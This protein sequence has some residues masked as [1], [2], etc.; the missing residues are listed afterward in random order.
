MEGAPSAI[1]TDRRI[2]RANAA[3]ERQS[4][5]EA[6][7]ALREIL[8]G[9][10]SLACSPFLP[11]L[12]S[13]YVHGRIAEGNGFLRALAGRIP[14]PHEAALLSDVWSV[15]LHES[16]DPA[17]AAD[18]CRI[19]LEGAPRDPRLWT[20]LG[21]CLAAAGRSDEAI[22]AV[23]AALAR[24]PNHLRADYLKCRASTHETFDLHGQDPYVTRYARLFLEIVPPF[25][26]LSEILDV[27]LHEMPGDLWI[28]VSAREE[29]SAAPFPARPGL[30]V[31]AAT[32]NEQGFFLRSGVVNAVSPGL[33]RIEVRG[34][35]SEG[36]W[37]QRRSHIRIS[38]DDFVAEGLRV[39]MDAFGDIAVQDISG[40]GISFLSLEG[41][42][43]GTAMEI[44]LAFYGETLATAAVVRRCVPRGDRFLVGAEFLPDEDLAEKLLRKILPPGPGGR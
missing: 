20:N 26:G 25:A 35:G 16:G 24:D 7:A 15:F 32:W 21:A 17:S 19:V 8:A 30:P 31:I 18:R 41:I 28:C 9:S 3:A 36:L 14:D 1:P 33:Q 29:S 43:P 44:T 40:G 27:S 22:D 13:L 11:L 6:V 5:P 4:W 38:A 12:K 23:S 10:A 2:A 37:I 39:S 34:T 42:A